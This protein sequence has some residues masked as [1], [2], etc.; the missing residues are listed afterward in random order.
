MFYLVSTNTHVHNARYAL[1]AS[2]N[3]VMKL[4]HSFSMPCLFLTI[5]GNSACRKKPP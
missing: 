3:L 4:Q 5:A 2:L 1:N